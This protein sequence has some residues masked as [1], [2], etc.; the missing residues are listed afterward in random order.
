MN[1]LKIGG[2]VIDTTSIYPDD[3]LY[4]IKAINK[5]ETYFIERLEH[6]GGVIIQNCSICG[7]NLKLRR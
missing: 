4:F 1:C 6:I 7:E 2:L 5:D 3:G